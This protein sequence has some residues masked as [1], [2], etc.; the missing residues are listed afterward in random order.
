[1]SSPFRRRASMEKHP[2][3]Y[4]YRAGVLKMC[5]PK[6]FNPIKR[7]IIYYRVPGS[8]CVCT[9]ACVFLYFCVLLKNT[10]YAFLHF[11]HLF[12][13]CCVIYF[14][15]SLSFLL[16]SCACGVR[17]IAAVSSDDDECIESS[18]TFPMSFVGTR[19]E[20]V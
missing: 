20:S 12:V 6:L 14:V 3:S 17:F 4:I 7:E 16:V 8:L 15:R 9:R 13:A 19:E 18:P 10:L 2:S 1:M 5:L 11:L